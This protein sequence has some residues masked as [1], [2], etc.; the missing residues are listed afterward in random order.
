MSAQETTPGQACSR[1]AF[2]SS[3]T[4][5][6][7]AEPTFALAAFSLRIVGVSSSSS[8]PSQPC[9]RSMWSSTMIR[10]RSEHMLGAF[11]IS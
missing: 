8:D 3:T 2:M 9:T 6:P 1:A 11:R 5:N 7:R 10:S 4:G